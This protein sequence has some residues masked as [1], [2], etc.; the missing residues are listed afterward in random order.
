MEGSASPMH[1]PRGA[2]TALTE[3]P[4]F[5]L[6]SH[7]SEVSYLTFNDNY[8][9]WE[10][11]WYPNLYCGFDTSL[12]SI[13]TPNV[14]AARLAPRTFHEWKEPGSLPVQ[15]PSSPSEKTLSD[16][17]LEEIPWHRP[18]LQTVPTPH[19]AL[20]P[21]LPGV[22]VAHNSNDGSADVKQVRSEKG[23]RGLRNAL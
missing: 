22:N 18:P 3:R 6:S 13:T 1:S 10:A 7:P 21:T 2:P 16:T 8:N 5:E 19:S 15:A 9:V 4:A 11:A 17:E 14:K 23:S 20:K 12:T